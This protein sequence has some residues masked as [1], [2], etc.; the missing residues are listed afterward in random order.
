MGKSLLIQLED[1]H[2]RPI[3]Y[4]LDKSH[5]R[6]TQGCPCDACDRY[7]GCTIECGVFKTWVRVGVPQRRG[8]RA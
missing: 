4:K 5:L 8:R 3:A 6:A 2:A 7:S 1:I